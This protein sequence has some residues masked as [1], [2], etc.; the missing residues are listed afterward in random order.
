MV[1]PFPTASNLAVVL[2]ALAALAILGTHQALA[3]SQPDVS[4][5]SDRIE[6]LQ[7]DV[8]VLQRQVARQRGSAPAGGGSSADVGASFID[9]TQGHFDSIDDQ[10]RQLTNRLEEL[11]NQVNQL[12]A[13]MD[14]LV[15]DVD[16]RLGAL[17]KGGQPGGGPGS[18]PPAAQ[19]APPGQ[20]QTP[21]KLVLV[22]GPAGAAPPAGEGGGAPA[23]TGTVE[24]PQ[25]SPEA[26]YEFAYGL[27]LQ[28]QRE[29]TDFSRPEQAF[30]EFLKANPN[31]RLAGNANY[32]LGETFYA[33]K[34]YPDAATTFAEGL[35]KYPKSEKAPDNLLKLGMA[36]AQLKRKDDACGAFAELNR[37]Y[38]NAPPQVKNTAQRERGRLACP[39]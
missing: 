13:R 38:P 2:A 18:P 24:L 25:G 28:A 11:T 31:H 4:G 19:N 35:K 36:L 32:W 37:R 33:R 10:M 7:R 9:Q 29:Q 16:F 22:P 12:S 1:R 27:L 30:R 21:G 8:D 39:G 20:P 34:D 15:K 14:K 26:Q 5:L 17:E 6:R 3:Q 23:S